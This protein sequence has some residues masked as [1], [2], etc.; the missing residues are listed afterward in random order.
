MIELAD[1]SEVVQYRGE[2]LP[3]V[4]LSNVMGVCGDVDSEQGTLDVVVYTENNHSVGLVVDRIIDIVETTLETM[5][6]TTRSG[7]TGSAV[8]QNHVTDLLD[9]PAVIRQTIPACFD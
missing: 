5:R 1:N 7:L 3:I 6:P 4:R 8:I 2:I 9:L